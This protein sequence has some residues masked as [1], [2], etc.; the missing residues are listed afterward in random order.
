MG[1]K[2]SVHPKQFTVDHIALI[3][4]ALMPHFK[5]QMV[6]KM[7]SSIQRSLEKGR[8]KMTDDD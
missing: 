8:D 7:L 6:E 1:L 5:N 3:F 4:T 2:L